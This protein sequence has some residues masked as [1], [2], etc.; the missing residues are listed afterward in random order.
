[1]GYDRKF[2]G[3]ILFDITFYM[4]FIFERYQFYK[5][6]LII[7]SQKQSVGCVGESLIPTDK[8]HLVDFQDKATSNDPSLCWKTCEEVYPQTS[9]GKDICFNSSK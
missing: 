6:L 7:V 9:L 4:H 3:N 2:S 1:M 8:A 5:I